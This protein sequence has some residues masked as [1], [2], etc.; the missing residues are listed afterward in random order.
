M[1]CGTRWLAEFQRRVEKDRSSMKEKDREREGKGKRGKAQRRRD[2]YRNKIIKKI[3][4]Y[5]NIIIRIETKTVTQMAKVKVNVQRLFSEVNECD[6]LHVFPLFVLLLCCFIPTHHESKF[7]LLH[8]NISPLA[9]PFCW[10]LEDTV[11]CCF[12]PVN[13]P[14]KDS[15][16]RL[17]PCRLDEIKPTRDGGEDRSEVNPASMM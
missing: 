1:L 11:P 2:T 14:D 13:S 3:K 6:L 10:A 17:G 15:Y 8:C 4:R 9:A 16:A 12:H 7:T 5:Y